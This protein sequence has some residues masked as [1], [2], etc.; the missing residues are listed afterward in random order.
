[1]ADFSE[2]S[3]EA[4]FNHEDESTLR[5]HNSS[6]GGTHS[7]PIK[8]FITCIQSPIVILINQV[9][10]DLSPEVGKFVFIFSIEKQGTW[11]AKT[12]G[13]GSYNTWLF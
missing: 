8:S 12:C 13:N 5:C 6:K 2:V 3:D 10:L 7:L 11:M 1:M 9:H 4:R